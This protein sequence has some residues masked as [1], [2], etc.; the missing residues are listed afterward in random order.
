MQFHDIFIA[1]TGDDPITG[2]NAT[3]ENAQ[4]VKLDPYWGIKPDDHNTLAA[5]ENDF[6]LGINADILEKYMPELSNHEL[7]DILYALR[8]RGAHIENVFSGWVI[9]WNAQ[10]FLDFLD[11][12]R[13]L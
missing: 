1:N 7:W 4:N 8:F 2:I 11:D 13:D 10:N 12:V 5:F 9:A 6:M 3:L